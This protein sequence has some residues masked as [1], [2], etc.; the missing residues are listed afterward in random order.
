MGF[1][2]ELWFGSRTKPAQ[3]SGKGRYIRIRN[4]NLTVLT[5]LWW[6]QLWDE[7]LVS[8]SFSN[9]NLILI[10]ENTQLLQWREWVPWGTG[11]LGII[12]YYLHL[13]WLFI[14]SQRAC[15]TL[16][17]ENIVHLCHWWRWSGWTRPLVNFIALFFYFR[18]RHSHSWAQTE[19]SNTGYQSKKNFGSCL[20]PVTFT[21][22]IFSHDT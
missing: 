9:T 5:C 2:T 8:I 7:I 14:T 13:M 20:F 1:V 16:I 19:C 17:N 22:S 11:T 4:I 3:P 10:F 21:S 18:V 15:G 6:H 12:C